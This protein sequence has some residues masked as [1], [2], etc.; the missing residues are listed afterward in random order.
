M[1]KWKA[2]CKGLATAAVVASTISVARADSPVP[3]TPPGGGPVTI[4]QKLGLGPAQRA[5][6]RYRCCETPVGQFFNN[7]TKPVGLFF[8]GTNG[9]L[10][11]QL[12][13]PEELARPGAEGAAAQ[14]QQEEAGAKARRAAVRY[15]GTVDCHWW[16]EAEKALIVALRSDRNECVRLEAALALG[17]GCCCTKPIIEAL[18]ICVS[19]S[20]KDGNP[21]ETSERVRAVAMGSLQHCLGCYESVETVPEVPAP[22][23]P[24]LERR[25]RGP[26]ERVPAPLPPPQPLPPSGAPPV[27]GFSYYDHLE[28]RSIAQVVSDARRSVDKL[29]HQLPAQETPPTGSRS[30]YRVFADAV[31]P[32]RVGAAS[33]VSVQVVPSSTAATATATAGLAVKPVPAPEKRATGYA[34]ASTSVT[35]A[36]ATTADGSRPTTVTSA[37]GNGGPGNIN[38]AASNSSYHATKSAFESREKADA[39]VKIEA[40][41]TVSP[42]ASIDRDRAVHENV[43]G[44]NASAATGSTVVA[45][46]KSEPGLLTVN[47]Q[48]ETAPVF[49]PAPVEHPAAAAAATWTAAARQTPV[50]EPVFRQHTVLDMQHASTVQDALAVLRVSD[51]PSQRQLAV[52]ALAESNWAVHPEVPASILAAATGDPAATVR[53][54]CIRSLVKMALKTPEVTTALESLTADRDPLVRSEAADALA[55]LNSSPPATSSTGSGSNLPNR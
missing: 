23:P 51:L 2:R 37:T 3:P 7:M 36:A 13:S 34:S 15:L 52:D 10:C 8:G 48:L 40:P 20:H 46:A 27:P 49:R 43:A 30:L 54:A 24:V 33:V 12:P 1:K 45:P 17:S 39:P 32:P 41:T 50:V 38:W 28:N 26:V 35:V 14:I 47:Q 29:T 9:L 21:S 5:A 31:N 42:S 16:P 55:S 44:D 4:W 22:P 19:G 18:A 53:A 25:E 11:P 6:R